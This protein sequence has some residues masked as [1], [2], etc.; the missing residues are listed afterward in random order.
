MAWTLSR[1]QQ[2][3]IIDDVIS[4]SIDDGRADFTELQVQILR[5]IAKHPGLVR[6]RDVAVILED[7]NISA[8]RVT[9]A[10]AE[11]RQK[12]GEHGIFDLIETVHGSGYRLGGA[13]SVVSDESNISPLLKKTLEL[14]MFCDELIKFVERSSF[15]E[16]HVGVQ[17]VSVD[18]KFVN[19]SFEKY[20][21]ICSS[22][23]GLASGLDGGNSSLVV[24]L[25]K[26][27]FTL[28]S[29]A[30]CW[31]IGTRYEEQQWK[32]EFRNEVLAH[33][34]IICEMVELISR[35]KSGGR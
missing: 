33:R 8:E 27:L 24:L 4:V 25:K 3:L 7:N 35:K 31:R 22:L 34:D 21:G 15:L 2:K 28:M 16:T 1:G 32:A 23:M 19:D 30:I 17:M 20:Y 12:L 14:G 5:A 10:I 11:V 13:W 18:R 9:K 6:R 26:Q 29:Y